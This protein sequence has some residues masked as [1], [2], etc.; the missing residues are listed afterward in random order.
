MTK[1]GTSL[2]PGLLLIERRG[3]VRKRS[4]VEE[5]EEEHRTRSAQSTELGV[6]PEQLGLIPEPHLVGPIHF[7]PRD[8]LV[9]LDAPSF[10][11][12]A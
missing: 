2:C 10:L 8:L 9:F 5:E 6:N 12:G 1:G 3:G 4:R 11:L 7:A